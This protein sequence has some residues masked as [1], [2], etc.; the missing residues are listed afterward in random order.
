[1]TVPA[2]P[3]LPPTLTITTKKQWQH[4]TVTLVTAA[5]ANND[6]NNDDNNVNDNNN[7]NNDNDNNNNTTR[8]WL[9][10]MQQQ[11]QPQ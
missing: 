7:D 3:S 4:Q 9:V 8:A 11:T 5:I 10:G 1:M 6:K 2:T